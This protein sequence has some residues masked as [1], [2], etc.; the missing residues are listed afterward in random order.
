ME[1][2]AGAPPLPRELLHTP[3]SSETTDVG[4]A[5]GAGK[6]T[7]TQ[8]PQRQEGKGLI[9]FSLQERSR[10]SVS[11]REGGEVRR[12]GAGLVKAVNLHPAPW[13]RGRASP[14]VFPESNPMDLHVLVPVL[15]SVPMS[16]GVSCPPLCRPSREGEA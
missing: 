8:C 3:S 16:L 14:F 13:L 15:V 11:G 2:E 10:R 9:L 6:V 7:N 1:A 4:A 12:G 5:V